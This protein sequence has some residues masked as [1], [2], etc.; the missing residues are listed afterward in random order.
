MYLFIHVTRKQ[1]AKT[2][3]AA[4]RVHAKKAT[5]EMEEIA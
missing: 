1:F 4:I 2:L 3:T 5:Q